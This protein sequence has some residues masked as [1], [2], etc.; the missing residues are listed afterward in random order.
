LGTPRTDAER[1][2]RQC[3]RFSRLLRVLQ[4][5]SGPGRYDAAALASEMECSVRTVHRNLQT[6]TMANVP[7]YFDSASQAYRVRQGFRL[8][9]LLETDS[10]STLPPAGL[11]SCLR[12]SAT[13]LIDNLRQFANQLEAF[14]ASAATED[15]PPSQSTSQATARCPINS[16][17]K[18]KRKHRS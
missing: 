8:V 15:C 18:R 14:C 9:H 5:I 13:A 12:H 10:A 3:E 11:P 17:P 1:R 7:W 6:L 16:R 2:A 4:L